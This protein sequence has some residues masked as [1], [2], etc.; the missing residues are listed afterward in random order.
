MED[1]EELMKGLEIC[2]SGRQKAD[3]NL[4]KLQ[5][6]VTRWEHL[7]CPTTL[8][9]FLEYLTVQ[10]FADG[11]K[12]EEI[13]HD[14]LLVRPRMLLTAPTAALQFETVEEICRKQ[15]EIWT[16]ETEGKTDDKLQRP[17]RHLMELL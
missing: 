3:E 16:V 9:T 2:T 1:Y 5:I 4:Q 17:L 14:L 15:T 6:E 11:I 8:E 13:Q 12:D 10:T 7:A